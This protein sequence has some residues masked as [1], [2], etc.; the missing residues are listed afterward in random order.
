[1]DRKHAKKLGA[2][3]EDSSSLT[4]AQ[5]KIEKAKKFEALKNDVAIL[6]KKSTVEEVKLQK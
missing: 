5:L 4:D 2:I 3:T 1:M 6:E